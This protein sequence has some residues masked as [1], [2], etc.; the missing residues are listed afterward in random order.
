MC[1]GPPKQEG[2]QGTPSELPAASGAAG[3]HSQAPKRPPAAGNS[4]HLECGGTWSIRVSPEPGEDPEFRLRHTHEAHLSSG[5][6]GGV[7]TANPNAQSGSRSREGGL[8]RSRE[9]WRVAP[10]GDWE[11]CPEHCPMAK[12]LALPPPPAPPVSL[13]REPGSREDPGGNQQG[14]QEPPESWV[15]RRLGW[16]REAWKPAA[17]E[18]ALGPFHTP[19]EILC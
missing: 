6:V 7:V 8:V 9:L 1:L 18:K 19:S 11:G 14:T 15:R 4:W 16:V 13:W 5:P 12:A 17:D 2:A 10:W 3:V